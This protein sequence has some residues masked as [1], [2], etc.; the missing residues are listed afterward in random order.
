MF[1]RHLLQCITKLIS[2]MVTN[3]T[4]LNQTI[5]KPAVNLHQKLIQAQVLVKLVTLVKHI[6]IQPQIHIVSARKMKI[7]LVA[8]RA[9]M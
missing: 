7:V 2:A 3:L 5:T 1:I 9:K 6:Y 8:L 4:S